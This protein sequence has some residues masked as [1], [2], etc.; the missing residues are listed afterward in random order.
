VDH[1]FRR[2]R[3]RGGDMRRLG[4]VKLAAIGSGTAERLTRYSLQADLVP[5]QFVADSLA[6]ALVAGAKSRRFLL[7]RTNRGRQ[8][9]PRELERAGGH[10]DQ[11]IVYGS[12]DVE[13]PDP[14]ILAS[15]S[16]GEIDWVT[17]TSSAIARAVVRLYG[18]ALRQA[19]LASIGPMTSRTIRELGYEPAV[20]ASPHSTAGL[21]EAILHGELEKS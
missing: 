19:R 21:I 3:D 17:V 6:Q 7:A 16:S 5:E 1:L 20:E 13:E 12:I 18:D 11:I 9:L 4:Q 8:V 14:A 10:V 2:L 15:L